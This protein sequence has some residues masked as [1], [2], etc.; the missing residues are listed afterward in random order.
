MVGASLAVV[1]S[2]LKGYFELFD[3]FLL[4]LHAVDKQ[5][6]IGLV[7]FWGRLETGYSWELR[8]IKPKGVTGLGL[9]RLSLPDQNQVAFFFY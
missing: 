6:H 7:A 4:L 3:G 2:V 9:C 5:E 8:G 1:R